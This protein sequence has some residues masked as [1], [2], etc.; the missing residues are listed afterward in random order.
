MKMKVKH[1]K[2]KRKNGN[3]KSKKAGSGIKRG[4]LQNWHADKTGVGVGTALF[5]PQWKRLNLD[6]VVKDLSDHV[7]GS[8]S[9]EECAGYQKKHNISSV[10]INIPPP[11]AEFTHLNLP[12]LCSNVIA[13]EGY[14]QPLPIQAVSW[15]I[16]LH[17]R[18]MVG[19]AATGSGKTLAFVIPA[20]LHIQKNRQSATTVLIL[21][22]TRELAL[23]IQQV[24]RLFGK[25]MN[26][27][28]VC[29]YGGASV[30]SQKQYLQETCDIVIATPGRL[31]Q[32]LEEKVI[33]LNKVSYLVL[34]EADRMLDMGFEP[35]IR[36][37]IKQIRPDRHTVM[38]S[39][40]WPKHVVRMAKEYMKRYVHV[41]IGSL[42]LTANSNI[43]QHVQVCK[44]QDKKE[45]FIQLID[46][47][48]EENNKILVFA[49]TRKAVYKLEELLKHLDVCSIHGGKT[50]AKRQEALQQFREDEEGILIAT[51]VAGRGL[52]I[53]G[54]DVV[55]N[56]DFPFVSEDYIH[57]IGR[58]GRV[59]KSGTAYTL[60]TP[61]DSS[62]A[63]QLIHILRA[64]HQ[65]IPTEL[66][67]LAMT[68][69]SSSS[70]GAAVGKRA[71]M[72]G[73]QRWWSSNNTKI[74]SLRAKHSDA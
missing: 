31:L 44:S 27:K 22:P 20:L 71:A 24:C 55:V 50:Q 13:R 54:V 7:V 58:T 5:A 48:V 47:L 18:D 3:K 21:A 42:D 16:I 1:K 73:M 29:I 64:A 63:T 70:H 9:G 62:K 6:P 38:Y 26:I 10:G 40:T 8:M 69:A 32:F 39:A 74:E 52:D 28:N 23:Q 4:K 65:D 45:I 67:N 46:M 30:S 36:Q 53:D 33:N 68:A 43:K 34:D 12:T 56:Y 57:R 49:G 59:H 41:T 25:E 51:D 14:K 19:I 35:Q 15:P 66:Q 2:D 61:K 72:P 37:V 17:G 11:I 60:I